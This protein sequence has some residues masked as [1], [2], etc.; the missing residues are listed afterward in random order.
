MICKGL[1]T[2]FVYQSGYLIENG[3]GLFTNDIFLKIK[4]FSLLKNIFLFQTYNNI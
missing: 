2:Q 4:K 1:Y 3:K